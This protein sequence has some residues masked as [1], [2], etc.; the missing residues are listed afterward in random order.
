MMQ[1]TSRKSAVR[2][3]VVVRNIHDAIEVLSQRDRKRVQTCLDA[4]DSAAVYFLF[5][6]Q[7]SQ[8]PNMGR[9]T[10]E[11]E[12]IFRQSVDRC[13]EILRPHLGEDLLPLLYP[14]RDASESEQRRLTDTLIAQPPIFTIEYALAS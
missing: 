13:C 3:S 1:T 8:H 2:R 5:P 4:N 11:S 9:Q 14:S 12:P 7:G 6:G 10:Y